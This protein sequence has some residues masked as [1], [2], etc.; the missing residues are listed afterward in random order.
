MQ[1]NANIQQT[2]K[3]VICHW[4]NNALETWWVDVMGREGGESQ[5]DVTPA[6]LL[7]FGA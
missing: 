2:K 6:R 5:I 7:S 4:M 3:C 1:M